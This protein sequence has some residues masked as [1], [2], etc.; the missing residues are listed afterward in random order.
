MS[1]DETGMLREILSLCFDVSEIGQ[2]Q[3]TGQCS[4]IG[5]LES[6]QTLDRG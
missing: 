3:M 6:I 4:C 2:M 5:K 1:N